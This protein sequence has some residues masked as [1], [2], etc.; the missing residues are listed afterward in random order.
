MMAAVQGFVLALGVV[1]V[2]GGCAQIEPAGSDI[3]QAVKPP[4]PPPGKAANAHKPAVRPARVTPEPQTPEPQ[5][6]KSPG[7]VAP[8]RLVGL[9]ERETRRLIGP[10]AAILD[11]PPAQVWAY[12]S[13]ICRLELGFYMD[14]ASSTFR[15]LTYQLTPKGGN[16]LSGD[17]CVGSVR[18]AVP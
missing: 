3:K 7:P 17:A 4:R 12:E 18:T 2:L 9:G 10:P 14:L 15:V 8:E 6:P 5:T 13:D 1:M 16:G 11:Q